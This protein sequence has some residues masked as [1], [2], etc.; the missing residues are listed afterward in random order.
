MSSELR[1]NP[2]LGTY[3]MVAANRQ[4]RPN[5]PKDW[6]PFCVG[7]GKVPDD[8]SVF[9]YPNDFPA[10]STNPSPPGPS[11]DDLYGVSESYGVCEVILFSPEHYANLHTLSVKHLVKLI[12]LWKE[13]FE[14]HRKDSR[15]KYIF[16]FENRGE[17]VGV[18]MPHPHGQLYGYPFVPLKIETE[19]SQCKDWYSRHNSDMLGDMNQ[20]ELKD[21]RRLLFETDHFL[22]YLP[23]FTDYPYGAFIVAKDLIG[24]FADFT[25]EHKLSL[26]KALQKLTGGF[27][28]LF[29]KLFPYMMCIHQIPVN[30][31][32]WEG[33]EKYY[34]FH[35]EFYP[36]LRDANRIKFYA[37]S[38]M[39]GWAAANTRNVEDTAQEL[40]LAIAK[41]EQ[42][43]T[44]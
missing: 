15:I 40:R 19:L 30:A 23:Y 11:D 4:G 10:L 33:C 29:D 14:L 6:C 16:E 44:H 43:T 39:G 32:E 5:M 34:R 31:K 1:W 20:K 42:A 8:Y 3:T 28:F 22:V 38:E 12:N 9:V 13:R 24:S 27:D 36:P 37:S 7:S 35:I 2:L 21:G 25:N 17:E 41:W 18:T 26:A